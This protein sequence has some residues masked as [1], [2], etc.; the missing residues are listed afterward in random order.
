MTSTIETQTARRRSLKVEVDPEFRQEIKI[1]AAKSGMTMR[2]YILAAL[3]RGLG[4]N[5]RDYEEK[6]GK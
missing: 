4:F 6:T 3:E 2:E 1:R 5:E